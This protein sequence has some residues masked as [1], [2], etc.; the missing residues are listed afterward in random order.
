MK[1]H[2]NQTHPELVETTLNS[3]ATAALPLAQ[4]DSQEMASSAVNNAAITVYRKRTDPFATAQSGALDDASMTW[5]TKGIFAFVMRHPLNSKV[6]LRDLLAKGPD[7][8]TTL[9]TV[10][11]ELRILGYLKHELRRDDIGEYTQSLWLLAD[12]PIFL[13]DPKNKRLRERQMQKCS[14]M[15]RPKT[16]FAA[17]RTVF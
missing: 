7:G 14:A 2:W 15:K 13:E 17:T 10:L 1:T 12:E 11:K 8:L 3:Y 9:R 5:K 6:P 4:P 16:V